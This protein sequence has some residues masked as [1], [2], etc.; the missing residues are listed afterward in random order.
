M[1]P[2]ASDA[3]A[4]AAYTRLVEAA[5]SAGSGGPSGGLVRHGRLEKPKTL[6][7]GTK[8]PRYYVMAITQCNEEMMEGEFASFESAAD[9]ASG[10][11]IT[12]AAV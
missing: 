2:F 7:G 9:A 8:P 11:E 6:T 1:A 4:T 10:G 5:V 12:G 3:Q